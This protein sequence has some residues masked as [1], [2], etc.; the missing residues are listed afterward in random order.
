MDNDNNEDNE[1][2]YGQKYDYDYL[3]VGDVKKV[4]TSDLIRKLATQNDL[5]VFR[6]QNLLYSFIAEVQKNLKLGYAVNIK[7]LVTMYPAPVYY[8]GERVTTIKVKV[9]EELI[10]NSKDIV[11]RL[12]KEKRKRLREI[13][14][15]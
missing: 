10:R 4:N 1:Q 13:D 2:K 3:S 11:P 15:D 14:T 6:T 5:N 12:A 7:G 9:S 8:T